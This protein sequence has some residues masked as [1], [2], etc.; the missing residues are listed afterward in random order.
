[1]R[2][3]AFLTSMEDLEV[4]FKQAGNAEWNLYRGHQDKLNSLHLIAAQR[5]SIS[6]EESWEQLSK[7]ID[8]NTRGGGDVTIYIPG[9]GNG[10][11]FVQHFSVERAGIAGVGQPGMGWGVGFLPIDEMERRLKAERERWEL[12]RRIEDLEAEHESQGGIW[13]PI[14]KDALSGIDVNS[15]IKM[16]YVGLMSRMAPGTISPQISING[17]EPAA[18]HHEQE[19]EEGPL[20]NFIIRVRPHFASDEE[21]LSFLNKVATFFEKS[22]DLCKNFFATQK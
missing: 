15:L 9:G 20:D 4:W 18:E 5:A 10:R 6:E 22:P 21:F 17:M 1:M 14:I 16:A 7:F 2:S 12:E 8:M 13:G 19:Y 3:K 11:G